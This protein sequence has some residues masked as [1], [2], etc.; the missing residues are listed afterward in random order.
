MKL[1]VTKHRGI[2]NNYKKK[3]PLF[4][5]IIKDINYVMLWISNYLKNGLKIKTF[6]VYPDYPGRGTTIYKAGRFLNYNIT[7]N[8]KADYEFA[9]YWEDITVREQCHFLD[10]TSKNK[11]VIN[12]SIRD[13]SKLHIDKI[14]KEIFGYSTQIDPLLYT[15]K[16]VRKNNLNAKHDGK[17]YQGP[18]N[19]LEQ[20]YIYQ[21]LIDNS[22]SDDLVMDIRVTVVEE[23]LD[24]VYIKY[25]LISE[26]FKN[27]TVVTKI[28]KTNEVFTDVEIKLL[29]SFCKKLKLEYGELDVLRDKNEN[30]IYVV[31]VNN[32]PHG[33][34]ANT[35]KQNSKFAIREI[36]KHLKKY[37][38]ANN[39]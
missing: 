3:T 1:F 28:K 5:T 13:I 36:A 2:F 21:I 32:T 9:I 31:D 19:S 26:R 7:N 10:K 20:G 11:H 38:T 37:T 8:P 12:M 6:L 24:F 34:P 29:N 4:E 18:I 39:A 14:H 15:G 27:T 33:P 30:R 22:Y 35:S 16:I 17:I 23:I 25:R